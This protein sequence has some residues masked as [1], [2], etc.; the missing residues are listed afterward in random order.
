ML[1]EALL[2]QEID[3]IYFESR[4][5]NVF[6]K[7]TSQTYQQIHGFFGESRIQYNGIERRT[8]FEIYNGLK[9]AEKRRVSIDVL[10]YNLPFTV[11]KHNR[12]AE[13]AFVDRQIDR[14]FIY[15][16]PDHTPTRILTD[17]VW[18]KEGYERLI[19]SNK[20]DRATVDKWIHTMESELNLGE[21][22][23]STILHEFGHILTFRVWD[24]LGITERLDL[25]DWFDEFGYLDNC[26]NRIV[27][28]S[29][30]HAEI[31]INT[32]IEQLAEDYRI[33]H[34]VKK[35]DDTCCLPHIISY[36]QDIINPEMFLEGVDIMTKILSLNGKVKI[37]K[38]KEKESAAF[39][40]I[41]PF[42]EANRPSVPA[43]FRHGNIT[44]I[45]EADKKRAREQLKK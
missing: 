14:R 17:I 8:N 33:S 45:T 11:L 27:S 4:F 13:T 6:D 28:F 26:S 24:R 44:P 1:D 12:P 34:D 22:V 36:E 5:I 25:Y 40:R 10:I 39:D 20:I 41:V 29:E 42:G 18:H 23:A 21:R 30:E 35:E 7:P 9:C 31:Q 15:L 43:R 38:E 19:E 3:D 37:E 2:K 16:V 32:C